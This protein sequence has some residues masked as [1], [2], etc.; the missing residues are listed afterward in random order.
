MSGVVLWPEFRRI[1]SKIVEAR[2]PHVCANCSD[3]IAKGDYYQRDY[4]WCG[5]Y[6]YL[7]Y[8]DG[9]FCEEALTTPFEYLLATL[10]AAES[11]KEA[12]GWTA[13]QEREG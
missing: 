4:V 12:L 8:C 6:Q 11:T 10:D 1:E 5:R 9:C 3:V 13:R 7:P 2:K